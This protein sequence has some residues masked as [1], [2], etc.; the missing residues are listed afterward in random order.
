MRTLLAML[1]ALV[2]LAASGCATRVYVAG[3]VSYTATPPLEGTSGA[4]PLSALYCHDEPNTLIQLGR[5]CV[6]AEDYLH[7]L[8]PLGECLVPTSAGLMPLRV[9]S[10]TETAW[11]YRGKRTGR[12]PLEVV[13]GGKAPD[14]R[15]L[16]YRFTEGGDEVDATAEDCQA[17]LAPRERAASRAP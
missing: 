9:Q 15:Y 13:L 1:V 7:G 6:L 5:D 17:L 12:T 10:A 2:A 3:T 16:T 4:L 14:G 8:H 11:A